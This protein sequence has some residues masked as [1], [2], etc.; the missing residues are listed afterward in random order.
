M[1]KIVI[2]CATILAIILTLS[3]FCLPSYSSEEKE[4]FEQYKEDFVL[5]T[6]YIRNELAHIENTTVSIVWEDNTH[7]FLSLYNDGD[8]YVPEN[9]M[10]AFDRINEAFYSDFSFIE[11]TSERISF[12]GLGSGMYVLS[13]NK[14]TPDYFYHKGDDMNENVYSLGD[15]WFYMH[16]IKR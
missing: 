16:A 1:K 13:L 15:N 8:I 10:Q 12:G 3:Y 2:I 14:K 11:I 9:I 5:I 6:E 4:K 7:K